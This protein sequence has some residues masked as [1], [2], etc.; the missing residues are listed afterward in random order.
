VVAFRDDVD[1]SGFPLSSK[2]CGQWQDIDVDLRCSGLSTS[3]FDQFLPLHILPHVRLGYALVVTWS[4]KPAHSPANYLPSHL[5]WANFVCVVCLE[6]LNYMYTSLS[7]TL[8]IIKNWKHQAAVE[9]GHDRHDCYPAT[10]HSDL[11]IQ[12]TLWANM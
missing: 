1:T 9:I 12:Q 10:H 4:L 11:Q 3:C 8:L 5:Q 6:S 7:R 2:C